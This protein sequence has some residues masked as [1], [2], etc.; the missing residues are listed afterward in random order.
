MINAINAALLA[1][2]PTNYID[3]ATPPSVSEQAW[4][5]TNYAWTPTAQDNTDM[6]NGVWPTSLH[7][8]S[9]T[10]PTHLN[11]TGYALWAY[12]FNNLVV[13]KGWNL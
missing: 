13:S 1:A 6:S 3:F 4:L 5:L 12:R 2:Y 10:D 11:D 8:S 9:G 7:G